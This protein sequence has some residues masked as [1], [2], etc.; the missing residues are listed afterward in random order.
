MTQSFPPSARPATLLPDD[1]TPAG[2]PQAIEI[3]ER[4]VGY[5]GYF[6]IDIYRLRHRKF[7]GSW[8][9]VMQRELFERGHAAAVLLYDPV[10]DAVV[11][12]DQF[13]IGAHAAGRPAWLSEIVAGIIGPGESVEDVARREA[14]EESG[15]TPT[16]LELICDYMVSPGGTTETCTLFCGRVDASTAGGVHGLDHEHE[17][18]RVRVVPVAEAFRLL[19]VNQLD[20]AVTIIALS[21]LARHHAALRQRWL[22]G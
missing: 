15:C 4:R 20:N 14:L 10:L 17:D 12:I 5:Q 16:T 22:A 21:W 3:L 7:D 11:L 18:I 8:S 13:R 1:G 9:G 19:D 6:R 2:D